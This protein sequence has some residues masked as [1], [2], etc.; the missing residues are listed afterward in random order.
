MK[1]IEKLSDLDG[2][3]RQFR[4]KP[5]VIS[6]V[7]LDEDVIILMREGQIRGYPRDLIIECVEGE[8]YPCNSEIFEKTYETVGETE[9]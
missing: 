5:V 9:E 1:Q 4:K 8:I 7:V 3:I 6:A 2:E